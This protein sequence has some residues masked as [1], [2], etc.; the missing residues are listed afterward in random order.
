MVFMCCFL[1]FSRCWK[2]QLPA[3]LPILAILHLHLP[4]GQAVLLPTECIPGFPRDNP[5][6]GMVLVQ[7]YS[8]GCNFLPIQLFLDPL[9]S[10][11]PALSAPR[12][13]SPIPTPLWEH[14]P[15]YHPFALN[16]LGC[17]FYHLWIITAL[18]FTGLAIFNRAVVWWRD[19]GQ[20]GSSWGVMEGRGGAYTVGFFWCSLYVKPHLR[21]LP[22]V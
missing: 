19:W 3:L 22:I 4:W 6:R 16:L 18:D 11:D 21:A 7:R 12:P 2:L 13:H 14:H 17:L 1:G 10:A 20:S 5:K 15:L 9:L 8:F